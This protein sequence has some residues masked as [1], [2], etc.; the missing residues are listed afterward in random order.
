MRL[1]SK[2]C[3]KKECKKN[4]L[5]GTKYCLHHSNNHCRFQGAECT[6]KDMQP[7]EHGIMMCPPCLHRWLSRDNKIHGMRWME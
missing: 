7:N 4:A 6:N 3:A 5:S 1:T 2:L